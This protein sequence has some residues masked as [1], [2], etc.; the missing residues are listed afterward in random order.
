M[1]VISTVVSDLPRIHLTDGDADRLTNLAFG[2]ER[3][4][5]DLAALLLKEVA[6]AE[7]HAIEQ[8]PRGVVTML[9]HVEF[10]DESTGARHNVQL[11]YPPDADIEA[12][13]ISV[14]THVG[15]GLIGLSEGQSILWPDRE[16]RERRLRIVRVTR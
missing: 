10:I 13:R 12:G 14:L 16:G 3:R 4:Q 6:R 11:V 7:I 2:L 9:A 5:P 15:A 1:T 8:L